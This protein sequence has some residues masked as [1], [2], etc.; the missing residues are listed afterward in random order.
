VT[1]LLTIPADGPIKQIPAD[2]S[3]ERASEQIT[4]PLRGFLR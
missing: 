1:I 3:V 4:E 2:I